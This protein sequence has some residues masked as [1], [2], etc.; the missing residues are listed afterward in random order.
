MFPSAD[1]AA[2]NVINTIEKPHEKVIVLI[3]TL[4]LFFSISS[5]GFPVM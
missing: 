3:R 1:A 5:K 4:F 2:P